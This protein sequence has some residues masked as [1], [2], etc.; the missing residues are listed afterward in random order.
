MYFSHNVGFVW[1]GPPS[2]G[3]TDE[4]SRLMPESVEWAIVGTHAETEGDSPRRLL[5]SGCAPWP[6]TR[7]LRPLPGA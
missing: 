7:T 3:D 2:R 4:I 6:R 5:W 1:P